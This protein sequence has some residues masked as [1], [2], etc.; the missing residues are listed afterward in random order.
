MAGVGLG[1]GAHDL[2]V[3]HGEELGLGPVDDLHAQRERILAGRGACPAHVGKGGQ[4]AVEVGIELGR[5]VVA[6]QLGEALR[7]QEVG[8][9]GLL[10]LEDRAHQLIAGVGD[11]PVEI[12]AGMVVPIAEQP[13][14]APAAR[15]LEVLVED[16]VLGRPL[17]AQVLLDLRPNDA[18][19]ARHGDDR[20]GVLGLLLENEYAGAPFGRLAGGG[21]AREAHADHQNVAVVLGDDVARGLRRVQERRRLLRLRLVGVRLC[22]EPRRRDSQSCRR[23]PHPDRLPAIHQCCHGMSFLRGLDVSM[24]E[25]PVS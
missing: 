12:L 18:K 2:A 6:L 22:A 5:V 11:E 13:G 20:V 14:V 9:V 23:D 3:L 1:V 4:G 16:D 25:T 15:L 7:P 24:P 17:D 10:V 21:D 8:V 19:V